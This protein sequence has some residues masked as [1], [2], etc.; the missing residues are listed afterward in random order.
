ERIE[1]AT[2]Q[3]SALPEE[4]VHAKSERAYHMVRTRGA[5]AA[6]VA[7]L[8]QLC[9]DL[10]D[11][12]SAKLFERLAREWHTAGEID[13]A[14]EC[15]RTLLQKFP[16]SPEAKAAFLDLIQTYS[17]GEVAHAHRLTSAM[18]TSAEQGPANRQML[19][20]AGMFSTQQLKANKALQTPDL[21]WHR[22]TIQ[23]LLGKEKAAI[24]LHTPLKRRPPGDSYRKRVD[25]EEWVTGDRESEAPI[26]TIACVYSAQRPHLDGVLDDPI[27][28][29]KVNESPTAKPQAVALRFAYDSE[30][31]YFTA[32]VERKASIAFVPDERPRSRDTDLSNF[33]RVRFL[34]DVDRDY[35]TA[36]E[37]TIDHRGWTS[38]ACWGDATWNPEWFVAAHSSETHWQVEVAV[39]WSSLVDSPPTASDAWAVRCERLLPEQ[40]V[41]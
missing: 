24:G 32:K 1:Q 25:F 8:L 37:M 34:L 9:R 21:D 17:S 36:Y 30:Y 39:A 23:R 4:V 14:G 26:P 6:S 5:N 28:N 27:W 29:G 10:P 2:Y 40:V 33:D 15:R 38:D 22:G 18:K 41:P 3:Q 11:K 31:L 7:L 35:A 16:S 13:L 19:T 20:Y 12:N